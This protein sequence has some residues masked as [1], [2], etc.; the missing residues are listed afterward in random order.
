MSLSSDEREEMSA[1]S[2]LTN[3]WP[4]F[5]NFFPPCL[6]WPYFNNVMKEIQSEIEGEDQFWSSNNPPIMCLFQ[7]KKT[8]EGA[9]AGCVG[10]RKNYG[11]VGWKWKL[12]SVCNRCVQERQRCSVKN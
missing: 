8:P 5:S 3:L 1:V 2:R 9:Y 10:F 11:Y 4:I 12:S 6:L 7:N